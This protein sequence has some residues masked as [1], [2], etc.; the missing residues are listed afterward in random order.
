MLLPGLRVEEEPLP[1]TVPTREELT[2]LI[3]KSLQER[4]GITNFSESSVA[5]TL[6]NVLAALMS[7]IYTNLADM[8]TRSNLSTA[9]GPYLDRIGELYGVTRL[10]SKAATSVG[11]GPSV[12]FT[13]PSA[14]TIVVP[15]HTRIWSK[16]NY[17]VAYY[18]EADAPI[19]PADSNGVAG[20]AYVDVTAAGPGEIYNVAPNTLTVHNVGSQ[21]L[22]VTNVR[23]LNNG[24]DLESDEN[25]RYR[26]KNAI[27]ARQGDNETALR[28]RLIALPGIRNI[29]IQ[30]LARGTGT[31]DVIIVPMDRYVTEELLAAAQAAA[32]EA[33]SLGV[34]VKVKPPVEHPVD[35]DIQLAVKASADRVTVKSL[36]SSAVRSLIDNL[37]MGASTEAGT[38][39]LI[40]SDIIAAAKNASADVR[41]VNIAKLRVDNR[42][43]NL[44]NQK[45]LPGERFYLQSI[46]V[47]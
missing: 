17:N 12:L 44:V 18:T 45:V 14:A 10:K 46:K 22:Q 3:E 27:L 30:P 4:A 26:I 35:I 2:S 1:I 21:L 11:G 47:V 31:V 43:A 37:P 38:G 39:D 36:V 7:D 19:P 41:D 33:V 6:S 29:E 13:N 8:E 28:M 5:G 40:L 42:P 15:A 9:Y 25:Y 24:T 20:K 23:S 34:S 16:N 32:Q